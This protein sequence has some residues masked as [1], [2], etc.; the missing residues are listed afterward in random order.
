ML[1]FAFEQIGCQRVE[2]R[3]DSLNFKSQ[4]AVLRIGAKYEGEL[5]QSALI[6]D[7]RKRDYKVYSILDNEWINV[8][9][10]LNWYLDKNV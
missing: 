4:N 9:T 3:V 10:T 5:R 6:P 7:G 8:K 2:F 1:G